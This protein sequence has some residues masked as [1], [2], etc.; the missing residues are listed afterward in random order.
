M[1]FGEQLFCNCLPIWKYRPSTPT[2]TLFEATYLGNSHSEIEV[3]LLF[4]HFS[5]YCHGRQEDG[6][7]ASDVLRQLLILWQYCY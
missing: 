4:K 3:R 5:E 6:N 1:L 2:T 7:I